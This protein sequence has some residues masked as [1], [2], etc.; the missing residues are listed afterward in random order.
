[1]CPDGVSIKSDFSEGARGCAIHEILICDFGLQDF[2]R[3]FLATIRSNI[4]DDDTLLDDITGRLSRQTIRAPNA[5]PNHEQHSA[6]DQTQSDPW[7]QHEQVHCKGGAQR[8][9]EGVIP[10]PKALA[11]V[12][13]AGRPD[14]HGDEDH[15]RHEREDDEVEILEELGRTELSDIG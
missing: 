3:E 12:C 7:N 13:G 6:L 2:L 15:K 9:P 1:M 14:A 4:R 10:A 8:G 11:L 5:K